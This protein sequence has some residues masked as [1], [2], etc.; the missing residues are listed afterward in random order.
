MRFKQV[1][2][3]VFAN[4]ANVDVRAE[5]EHK[6]FVNVVRLRSWLRMSLGMPSYSGRHT[7]GPI[8][9]TRVTVPATAGVR[10]RAA[11]ADSVPITG[12]PRLL[13]S[14]LRTSKRCLPGSGG[15]VCYLNQQVA[16]G[17]AGRCG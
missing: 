6:S 17:C 2:A 12:M 13:R 10:R 4:V 11:A 3:T 15:K 5:L 1:F 16:L 14:L 9:S 8:G 7:A